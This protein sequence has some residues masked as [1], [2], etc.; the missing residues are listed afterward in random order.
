MLILLPPSEAKARATS[1]DPYDLACAP[2][3][4][5]PVIRKV[6]TS[7]IRLCRRQPKTARHVL[8]LGA[9][10][11]DLITLNA[12]LDTEPSA[13]SAQVYTGVLF[14]HLQVSTM[15]PH[16]QQWAADNLA[17]SSALFG[18]VRLTDQ[19]PAYRLSAGTSLPGLEPLSKLWQ[20]ALQK[21]LLTDVDAPLILDLRSGPYAAL[22]RPT[23]DNAQR[24]VVG[25]V[26]QAG[27]DG[28]VQATSHANKAVKG[29]LV[30]DLAHARVDAA[31]PP[32][33]AAALT[34]L[35]WSVRLHGQQLDIFWD[36]TASAASFNA[37]H[38]ELA[39]R[40]KVP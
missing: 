11:A 14:E 35:G 26:W 10:G 28:Q 25:K 16:A 22:W 5:R 12:H 29:R 9:R 6:R 13:P 33:L 40:H 30:R 31:E 4:L 38:S 23:A 19:I 15:S 36:H 1:G 24:V 20:P 34:D 3:H 21:H 39:G 2:K 32:D 27:V 18:L 8:K 37:D 7:L 17:I